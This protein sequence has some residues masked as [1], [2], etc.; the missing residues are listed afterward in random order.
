MIEDIISSTKTSVKTA[1]DTN[2]SIR[3]KIPP[4]KPAAPYLFDISTDSDLIQE[5][6]KVIFHST[7]DKL[8]CIS[9]R[10]RQDLFTIISLLSKRVLH[11]TQED[12]KKLQWALGYLESTKMQKLNL[13]M[14][15]SI[16]ICFIRCSPRIQ[17]LHRNLYQ[18]GCRMLLC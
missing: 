11:P 7:V 4:R 12:W 17:I 6:L 9:T 18:S 10:P 2:F 1:N 5:S 16:T 14:T 15:E 3:S 13:V 8:I